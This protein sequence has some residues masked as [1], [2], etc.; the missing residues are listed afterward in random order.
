MSYIHGKYRD[1]NLS[2]NSNPPWRH[3]GQHWPLCPVMWNALQLILGLYSSY[4]RKCWCINPTTQPRS[5]VGGRSAWS[6]GFTATELLNFKFVNWIP[7]ITVKSSENTNSTYILQLHTYI[8][9]QYISTSKQDTPALSHIP[10]K[11][12]QYSRAKSSVLW[13]SRLNSCRSVFTSPLQCRCVWHLLLLW[14]TS[15]FSWLCQNVWNPEWPQT[16]IY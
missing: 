10:P 11:S 2:D 9:I 1:I 12:S 7:L 3:V 13:R 15:Y 6:V 4:I 16:L 5:S 14:N 8:H